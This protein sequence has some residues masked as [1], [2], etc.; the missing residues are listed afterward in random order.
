MLQKV[1]DEVCKALDD[2]KATDIVVV[3]IEHMT[4][5]AEKF[6]IASGRSG[7]QVKGLAN[8]VEATLKESLELAPIRVEGTGESRWIVMDYGDFIVHIFNEETRNLYSLEKLWFDGANIK[9]F[10]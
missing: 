6:V 4:T 3:S 8:S 1:I 5:I 9:K 7:P 10:N 2:K